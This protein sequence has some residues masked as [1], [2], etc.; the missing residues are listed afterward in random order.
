MIHY[1]KMADE[2]SHRLDDFLLLL[3]QVVHELAA[4]G[5]VP[6]KIRVL[7]VAVEV[8]EQLCVDT[9]KKGGGGGKRAKV[10]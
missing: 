4:R 8:L 10:L 2:A 1:G 3:L 5:I 9:G 6:Q 7:R